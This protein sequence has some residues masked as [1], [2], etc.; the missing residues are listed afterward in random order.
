MFPRIS[1]SANLTSGSEM[2]IRPMTV[3]SG[4]LLEGQSPVAIGGLQSPTIAF[5]A[6]P[7][8]FLASFLVARQNRRPTRQYVANRFSRTNSKSARSHGTAFAEWF[9]L[10]VMAS[11]G[12]SE[13]RLTSS[14]AIASGLISAFE[15]RSHLGLE[16]STDK[17]Q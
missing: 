6:Q 7:F 13:N 9:E 3:V 11:F 10:L 2:L 5:T 8:R 1:H 14:I 12:N 17:E 15:S 4:K 16:T